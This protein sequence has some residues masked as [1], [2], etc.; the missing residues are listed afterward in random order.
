M[1]AAA[2]ERIKITET[3]FTDLA[4]FY[5]FLF[6]FGTGAPGSKDMRLKLEEHHYSNSPIQF[7][8]FSRSIQGVFLSF[9]NTLHSGKTA[10]E[11]LSH[12]RHLRIL[13]DTQFWTLIEMGHGY[14]E[15]QYEYE[16]NRRKRILTRILQPDIVSEIPARAAAGGG[17]TVSFADDV[18]ASG[19]AALASC[20]AATVFAPA[21][22]TG[23]PSRSCL[24]DFACIVQ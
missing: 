3:E 10:E 22:D 2:S 12:F 17:K 9:Y 23:S 8:F 6:R 11:K 7:K 16:F 20:S 1:C 21:S 4:G 5:M 24:D 13:Y 18:A 19:S 15:K 14:T